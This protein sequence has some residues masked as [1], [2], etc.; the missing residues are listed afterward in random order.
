MA[1]SDIFAGL[2]ALTPQYDTDVSVGVR[3]PT[4]D[5]DSYLIETLDENEAPIR[6]L[7]IPENLNE[8]NTEFAWI[9]LGKAAKHTYI[10]MDRLWLSP[11]EMNEGLEKNTPRMVRY[12]DSY[13]TQV[14]NNRSLGRN[15]A[16]V[17]DVRYN[18]G[19]RPWIT[20]TWF[21]VDAVVT[22]EEFV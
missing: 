2:A 15:N 4:T 19:W 5:T 12:I 9:A 18:Y 8:E 6:I 17:V 10:I 7:G 22:V 11:A 3:W 13:N 20:A 14:L 1:S 21:T 16:H